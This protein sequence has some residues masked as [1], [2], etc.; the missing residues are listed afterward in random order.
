MLSH[1]ILHLLSGLGVTQDQFEEGD[2]ALVVSMLFNIRLLI[3]GMGLNERS[4][5]S[6]YILDDGAIFGVD[7]GDARE[8]SEE[9]PFSHDVLVFES[10]LFFY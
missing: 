5:A 1:E 7:E 6:L 3:F 2:V 10:H 8:V 9:G 4:N